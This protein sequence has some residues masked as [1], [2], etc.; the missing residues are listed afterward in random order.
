[1]EEFIDADD[2]LDMLFEKKMC[3]LTYLPD[4]LLSII[5][6]HLG[7]HDLLTLSIV[8]VRLQKVVNNEQTWHRLCISHRLCYSASIMRNWKKYFFA[9]ES[10]SRMI[11]DINYYAPLVNRKY[12]TGNEKWMVQNVRMDDDGDVCLE[13]LRDDVAI[14]ISSGLMNEGQYALVHKDTLVIASSKEVALIDMEDGKPYDRISIFS[15]TEFFNAIAYDSSGKYI[16]GGF[17]DGVIKCWKEKSIRVSKNGIFR[18]TTSDPDRPCIFMKGRIPAP[19]S[20]P[21]VYACMMILSLHFCFLLTARM[22]IRDS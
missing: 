3:C 7:A 9:C 19:P 14:S 22:P 17:H 18:G 4:E 1:M 6:C 20:P 10:I 15:R 8:A 21:P 2:M 12:L 11:A 13:T 5:I 16:F